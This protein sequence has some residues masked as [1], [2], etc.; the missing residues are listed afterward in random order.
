MMPYKP[1]MVISGARKGIGRYLSDYYLAKGWIVYGCSRS[2]SE[3]T[4]PN[5]YHV[6]LDVADEPAVVEF[7]AKIKR[8]QGRLDAVVNNAGVAAMNHSM[9]T[10]ASTVQSLLSTN[11]LGT[12]LFCREGA[13]VMRT[14]KF[15]RIVNFATVATPIRLEGEAVY[16]ASKAA[17]V[18]LT[19][20]LAYEL[21]PFGITVNAVGPT[22]VA[23]DLTRGVPAMKIQALIARQAIR[24]WG[25]FTDVVNVVDFFLQPGSSFVTGQVIYLG[26]IS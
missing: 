26:G 15:G 8:D 23:T 7:F 25:E 24:R 17:V 20:I 12:F 21:A 11:V 9:L 3:L 6:C 14:G 2:P 16:A 1:V 18:C 13:K 5:Y 4:H 22:P 10:P 19:E